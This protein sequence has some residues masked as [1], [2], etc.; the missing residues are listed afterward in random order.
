PG[1][2]RA[3]AAAHAH[4]HAGPPA[5]AAGAGLKAIAHFSRWRAMVIMKWTR[6]LCGSASMSQNDFK[7]SAIMQ[8]Q[9]A[10][11][12]KHQELVGPISRQE[13]ASS[14]PA[15]AFIRPPHPTTT[16]DTLRSLLIP[17]WAW[18]AWRCWGLGRIRQLLDLHVR[19]PV[20][21]HDTQFRVQGFHS[22]LE[23][24]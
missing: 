9:E 24:Q 6:P 21:K 22:R 4:G 8:P 11:P 3:G 10:S 18:R 15:R 19:V 16:S 14:R 12:V 2:W 23:Q 17:L 13:R 7:T 20:L 5:G 1:V